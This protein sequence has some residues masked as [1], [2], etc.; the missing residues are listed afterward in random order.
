MCN[1]FEVH[2]CTCI[3]IFPKIP[4]S[5]RS[6]RLFI[7]VPSYNLANYFFCKTKVESNLILAR[8]ASVMLWSRNGVGQLMIFP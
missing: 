1:E 5:G 4:K 7:N 8:S 2:T 3:G 6:Q